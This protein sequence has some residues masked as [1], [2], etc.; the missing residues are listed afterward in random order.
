[1]ITFA[2]I[3]KRIKSLPPLSNIVFKINKLYKDGEENVDVIKL[4]RLIQSD[5]TLTANVLKFV[6][7]PKYGFSKKIS[8][9]PQAVTL[10]GTKTIYGIVV[11]HAIKEKLKADITPYGIT[12]IQFNDMCHLQSAL[13][14]QWFS[15]IDLRDAQFLTSL[16]L[17]MEV[18]KLIVSKEILESSYSTRFRRGLS[19]T[20]NV[21]QY[22]ISIFD[23]TSYYVSALLFDE[24]NLDSV[25]VE[26]LKNL[27][28]EIEGT[29]E[30]ILY[31]RDILDVVRTAVSVKGILTNN[32]I[33][34]AS[35]LVKRAGLSE[36]TFLHIALRLKKS[37]EA[38]KGLA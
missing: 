20:D 5:V 30:R 31:L 15:H 11:N 13:M 35:K 19:E 34:K 24:W 1:M 22:E 4:I 38:S 9:L 8:S 29:S 14:L 6:N 37:Y 2:D 26:I 12:N 7:D 18:G 28:F 36:E 3:V 32:S 21:S 10:L 33:T 17:I 25:F 23:T 16:A 27:D